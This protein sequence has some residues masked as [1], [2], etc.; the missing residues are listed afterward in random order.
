MRKLYPTLP[1][2]LFAAG[3]LLSTLPVHS[4]NYYVDPSFAGASTGTLAKPW[5]NTATVNSEQWR[6]V[7]GDTIFFKRGQTFTG[8]LDIWTSGTAAASIVFMPY[9][10]GAVPIMQYA[11]PD[12]TSPIARQ[13][14]VTSNSNYLVFDGF[15]LVDPTIST[16]DHT[17]LANIGRGVYLY[18]S[19]NITVKNLN[20]SLVG[21]GVTIEGNNNLVTNCTISNLREIVNTASPTNDDFGAEGILITGSN[22]RILSNSITECWAPS[23]DYT[24]DGGAMEIDGGSSNNQVLYNTTINNDGFIQINTTGSTATA[25]N[26]MI[27]YNLLINNGRVFWF[28]FWGTLTVQNFQFFNNDIIET[29]MQHSNYPYMFGCDAAPSNADALILKNNVFWINTPVD[30]TYTTTKPF[31]GPQMAHKNN[32]YHLS[33]G[34]LGYTIDASETMLAAATV[35][36]NNTTNVNP[37][38]WDYHVSVTSPAYNYGQLLGLTRDFEANAVPVDNPE[39]GIYETRL[40]PV[41]LMDFLLWGTKKNKYNLLSWTFEDD[42]DADLFMVERSESGRTFHVISSVRPLKP[43]SHLFSFA[44]S[45]AGNTKVYYRIKAVFNS[46]E[47]LYSSV[48]VLDGIAFCGN[49]LTVY[50]NPVSSTATLCTGKDLY[51]ANVT[52]ADATGRII[53]Q[54]RIAEHK[55]R[56]EIQMDKLPPGVYYIAISD[57]TNIYTGAVNKH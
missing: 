50:P 39:A 33:G 54:L 51:N 48:T 57:G 43:E 9:G 30:L 29:V 10:A 16:T 4:T 52:M 21:I 7:G 8:K 13:I 56:A 17:I 27:A 38:L 26:N 35:V 46:G 36:F 28:N 14:I 34:S 15:V 41:P 40:I 24:C 37:A 32:L 44:D 49:T 5:K 11:L 23:S 42:R 6:F 45:T 25:S 1:I 12:A 19:S 20:I 22:N 2:C 55:T 3:F 31:N 47:V 18:Q 53:R